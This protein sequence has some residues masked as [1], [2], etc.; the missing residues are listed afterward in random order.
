MN[1]LSVADL[2]VGGLATV[3]DL[4]GRVK[5]DPVG[6]RTELEGRTV[7]LFFEKQSLRTWVS[8]D[9]AAVQLGMHPVA[10]RGEQTGL[11]VRESVADVGRVLERYLDALGMRV[12][13]H[14]RLEEM[15]EVTRMPLINLLSDREHPVQV[16]ADL[17]TIAELRPL[18]GT[19]LAF[20][21]D[22]N[23]VA[24]SLLIGGAMAGLEVRVASPEGYDPPP[25]VLDVAS[26][27]GTVSVTRSPEDAVAGAHVVYTDV[28]T[29][30]GQEEE[31]AIRERAFHGYTVTAEL[32]DRAAPDAFF[33]HDLPAHRGEEVT[34]EVIDGPRSRVFEQAENRLHSFKG[35]L[36]HL[37]A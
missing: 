10:I 7:G 3:L 26:S 14:R 11:G 36:L 22:G 15:A 6:Y 28:W 19:V 27:F 37:L 4:S 25:S 24:N 16:L 13:D 5:R 17:M 21:G 12:Y 30:M 32:M 2:G 33:M 8:S 29:S 20:I 34:S 35:L 23:N 1:L 18:N 31:A 9:V